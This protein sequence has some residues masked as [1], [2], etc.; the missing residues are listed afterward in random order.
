MQLKMALRFSL[1]VALF[2]AFSARAGESTSNGLAIR[3]NNQA[4]SI[5]EVEMVFADSYALIQD[6]V[7]SGELSE[8]RLNEAIR[9]AWEEALN[10]SAQDRLID[11]RADKRRK[12]II[13]MY[14][15]R[16]GPQMGAERAKAYFEREEA[17]YLR[18]LRRELV[19][20]AGGEEELR[21]ALKRRGQTLR[22]WE[23]GLSRELFRR[24]VM[25]LE[26]GPIQRSP[27][28]VR[29]FYEN[30]PEFFRQPEAWRLKRIRIAKSKFTSPEKALEAANLVKSKIENGGDFSQVATRISDDPEFANQGGLLV[31]NERT[32]L[33]S[34]AFPAEEKIASALED[35]QIS[36][37][38]DAGDWYVLVQRVGYRKAV[39]QSFEEAADRAEA[40]MYAE[41][42][43]ERKREV[44][45]KLKRES[46]VEF[47]QKDP[48]EH[49]LKGTPV[50]SEF[51]DPAKGR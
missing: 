45:E 10:T 30:N 50:S 23:D 33:P 42:L 16:G 5:R 18:K 38:V 7:R 17:E 43:R 36:A 31:R 14:T 46:Y 24:D 15:E 44:F 11:Q 19:S 51:I 40:L 22:E 3:V 1:S 27:S 2:F 34:G 9:V 32:D 20:A 35:G 6:K 47:I 41:K 12:D 49:L 39:L 21:A 25:S 29:N 13:R 4:V 28:A 26:L 37:P 8:R 48:P